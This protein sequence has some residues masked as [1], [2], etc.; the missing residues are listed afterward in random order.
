MA[1]AP[2]PLSRTE[3]LAVTKRNRMSELETRY[4]RAKEYEKKEE[5]FEDRA[6]TLA[7]IRE[8]VRHGVIEQG[9]AL[10]ILGRIQQVLLDAYQNEGVIMEYEQLRKSLQEQFPG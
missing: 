9:E 1:K 8:I 6:Q 7:K 5:F 3:Q 2:A 4:L 10:M